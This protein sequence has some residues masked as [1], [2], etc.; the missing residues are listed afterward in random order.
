MLTSMRLRFLYL[1]LCVVVAV[2]T[3]TL[4]STVVFAQTETA[5][6]SG[7]VT[8]PQGAVVPGVEVV[9]TRIETGTILTIQT[10]G[11]GI[12]F[13]TGLMPGH[14]HLVLRK[15]GFKEIAIKEIELH[16]QDKLERNFS[17]DI[18]SLSETVN[19]EGGATLVNTQD[20]SVGTVVDRKFVENMPLNG[21]SFQTLMTLTPGVV[22]TAA[23]F[24]ND[25][26][27][28]VNGQRA[29]ANYFTVDGASAN[30][31][32][33]VG[34]SLVESAGGS[35]PGLAVTGGTNSLVSVD[36]MQEF[37][38]Q[39]SSF[40]PEFGRTPGGQVSI[41][42]RS[43]TNGFHGTLFDYLRNDV[44]DARD[45]FVNTN[46]LSKPKERQNDFG[47]VFG[48]PII[49]DKTFFFF[50][51]EGLRL[52]QPL[53]ATTVVPSI[54]SRKSAP[55]ALQAF[56]N[57]FPVPN[58]TDYGNNTA[59][60]SASYS[61]PSTLNSYSL[62]VDHAINSK[63]TLFGRYNYSAS[64]AVQR[65]AGVALSITNPAQVNMQT[66]T[67]GLTQSVSARTSNEVRA[68]YSNVKGGSWYVLD[69]FGKAVPL[70]DSLMFSTGYS[71]ANGLF[72][73]NISGVGAVY[74]GENTTNK[75]RQINLVDNV[76]VT[77]GTHQLKFGVDYRWLAP[78]SGPR[79]YKQYATFLG[80]TGVLSGL[81]RGVYTAAYQSTAL[82]AQNFSLYGQD[83]WKVTPRLALTYGL[84]WDVNPALAGKNSGSD[85]YTI[86]GLDNPATMSLAS[87]GTQLYKTTYGNV[88][89]RVGV[90]YQLKQ[91]PG[92]E[93]A[94]RGGFGVFYDLGVGS[95]GNANSGFP[96]SAI[97]YYYNV[98]YPLT[99]VQAVPPT[100][101]Q[102]TPVTSTMWVADPNLKLP[103]TYQWNV[104]VEQSLGASQTVS[105]TYIGALGRD[106]LRQDALSR[107]NLNFTSTVYVTRNTGTSDY[108][109]LQ[110]KFQRRLS[111]GLQ[112]LASY[113]WSH[114]IDNA[115]NDSANFTP[116]AIASVNADRGNSDFDIR[117]SFTGA[118]T[119]DF[120]T[121]WK[122]GI[123]SSILRDWSLDNFV[124]VRSAM[125]VDLTATTYIVSGSYYSARP[126][127]VAGVPLNLYGSQYP[128]GG[129]LNPA[130]FSTPASGQQGNLGRNVL[131]GF[132]A[133]QA[134][135]T[136]RRQFHL[137]EKL[138]LQ[139]RAEF[140]NLF[141]HPNFGPPT[142]DLT[143]SLF[144]RSTQTLASSLG[145]GGLSGGFN[146][147]YQIGGPRSIQLALKLQ[148]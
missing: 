76:S 19:V 24:G 63:L 39:T 128:G 1:L 53:A 72:G 142:I 64:E 111:R 43:G 45:W 99:S 75:Q 112:T 46:G 4:F 138:G 89:P 92:K 20:A 38:I 146:S 132:G 36:A 18:G 32:V 37:R 93:T 126:N 73:F 8:D 125:P 79:P 62:R 127:V 106:L 2:S 70:S 60:F 96:F 17:L 55:A 122:N 102:S 30:I 9:A 85:L 34:F 14:Y 115:S 54:A 56:L 57:A 119:Y 105:A 90:A 67:L 82:L 40:A 51:Y 12:Y 103:R 116:S 135:L 94:L 134:D 139:F 41:V 33:S 148:F 25:G 42:T 80:M 58:G 137:T 98:P 117:H 13:L 133:W 10:N 140:F 27:F 118:V 28:S 74:A 69:N 35:L 52:R 131:R 6:L 120:P 145:T 81:A 71:S 147:L 114:S 100:I 61:D 123:A 47:G 95:L 11:A 87:R 110:L 113:T 65:G 88:A 130:A 26:Q 7:V 29:N 86:Q 101:S 3:L 22:L 143:S 44:L 31:G 141:N 124:T 21:R 108:H 50:S 5:T 23:S 104:A 121:P 97:Q 84:R 68:N 48:G 129:I 144:G 109:A 66:F 16:V 78:I 77:T 107:P 91:S 136:L 83:T 15:Q 59:V 49:K